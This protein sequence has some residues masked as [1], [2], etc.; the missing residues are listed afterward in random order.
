VVGRFVVAAHRGLNKVAFRGR[1][2]GRRL[3]AGVYTI[4]PQSAAGSR[5]QPKAVAVAIDA[6]GIR[7]TAPV[8]WRNCDPVAA[9]VSPAVIARNALHALAPRTSGVA[10]AEATAPAK[11]QKAA[12]KRPAGVLSWFPIVP[13]SRRLSALLLALL[14]ASLAL[15]SVAAV[16][17]GRMGRH[18]TVRVIAD[19][20][21]Q[22]AC[23][24]GALLFSALLLYV[25]P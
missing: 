19:H 2:H 16:E 4:V 23:V 18:R 13:T 14:A 8:R 3:G 15:L 25:L 17:P 11:G 24:G 7:P 6:R 1:V 12:E 9:A 10:A 22:I 21:G 5:R 20:R